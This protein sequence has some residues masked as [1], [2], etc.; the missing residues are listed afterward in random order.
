M[1]MKKI[2]DLKWLVLATTIFMSSAAD[3]NGTNT[4]GGADLEARDF[5]NI[6]RKI[7]THL[8]ANPN[9]YA[10]L[11]SSP[12]VLNS[13]DL[14]I[15][16]LERSLNGSSSK[17]QFA[18]DQDR[19]LCEK[20]EKQACTQLQNAA[21]NRIKPI[22]SIVVAENVWN[23]SRGF[24]HRCQIVA[25]EFLV[26]MF[27]SAPSQQALDQAKASR[28][29]WSDLI[30]QNMLSESTTPRNV[31][32][33]MESIQTVALTATDAYDS[34]LDQIPS[35]GLAN[36]VY[37]TAWYPDTPAG[38]ASGQKDVQDYFGKLPIK[39]ITLSQ[40][41]ETETT[42]RCAQN[43]V[44]VQREDHYE[45]DFKQE[46][47]SSSDTYVGPS[48]ER[49]SYRANSSTA[50]VGRKGAYSNGESRA[51]RYDHSYGASS[52]NSWDRSETTEKE[53]SSSVQR[54]IYCEKPESM[55]RFIIRA[56]KIRALNNQAIKEFVVRT[57]IR[58]TLE[59]LVKSA[60]D[61]VKGTNEI[62]RNPD[63]TNLA[64]LQ[65]DGA[66]YNWVSKKLSAIHRGRLYI[67]FIKKTLP[68]IEIT[69]QAGTF[70]EYVSQAAERIS[71]VAE[72]GLTVAE[73]NQANEARPT[74]LISSHQLQ[75]LAP[76]KIFRAIPGAYT[77]VD[78]T[79][80]SS[81]SSKH[82]KTR[83]QQACYRSYVD[84]KESV[85]ENV[86]AAIFPR[87]KDSAVFLL[88]NLA[89][90]SIT[91]VVVS[92]S[93]RTGTVR[94]LNSCGLSVKRETLPFGLS[95]NTSHSDRYNNTKNLVVWDRLDQMAKDQYTQLGC[96]PYEIVCS[97]FKDS[98]H[99]QYTLYPSGSTQCEMRSMCPTE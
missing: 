42:S 48:R 4:G 65:E 81:V 1:N 29:Q 22:G 37:A 56:E 62:I 79:F 71:Q 52:S 32:T 76:G 74:L 90:K 45:R 11:I 28:N 33:Q 95:Y 84:F 88:R 36:I 64:F 40:T 49:G 75:K 57:H 14:D 68:T 73:L 12:E 21:S 27:N 83:I 35:A 10:T 16:F 87:D 47:E 24:Y 82:Q 26:A 89:D 69:M 9:I 66:A 6:G 91:E 61:F 67:E 23:A 77:I 86:L 31:G 41:I 72:P 92:S 96:I 44:Y 98:L 50:I 99:T 8:R 93:S 94:M 70:E 59:D 25:R 7:S 43:S 85:K 55:I 78:G 34:Y 53:R 80:L 38:I 13:M 51:G 30:C 2:N 58:T 18:K 39:G 63:A 19:V 54:G 15:A 17:L 3:A 97:P 20:S 46:G 5:L 60:L